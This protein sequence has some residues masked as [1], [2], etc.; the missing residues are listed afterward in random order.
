MVETTAVERAARLL[1]LDTIERGGGYLAH[2][3]AFEH[4]LITQ[5]ESQEATIK[6]LTEALEYCEAASNQPHVFKRAAA[7][8]GSK[9]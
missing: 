7:A 2:N 8:L 4:R 6:E 5:V 3:R 1:W 9:S